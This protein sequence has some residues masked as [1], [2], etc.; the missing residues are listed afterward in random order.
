M[1]MEIMGADAGHRDI[2]QYLHD[3]VADINIRNNNGTSA[4]IMATHLEC[5][6]GHGDIVEYKLV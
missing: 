4:E 3:V 5:H 6:M 2:I 1:I